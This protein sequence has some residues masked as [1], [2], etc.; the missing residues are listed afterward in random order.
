MNCFKCGKTGHRVADCRI[1]N[2]TCFNCRE[3]G[4]ISTQRE[5]PKK[6]QTGGKVF[7]SNRA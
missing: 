5:K 6:A 3:R 4:H 1:N 7:A 2:L